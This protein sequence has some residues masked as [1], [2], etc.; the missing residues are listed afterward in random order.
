M[1]RIYQTTVSP[2]FPLW[3]R[4]QSEDTDATDRKIALE[5][6]EGEGDPLEIR[7]LGGA[8]EGKEKRGRSI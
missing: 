2:P 3:R 5:S 4:R 1:V 7:F 8:R 6:L